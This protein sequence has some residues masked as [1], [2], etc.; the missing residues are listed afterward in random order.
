MLFNIT[1]RCFDRYKLRIDRACKPG[2]SLASV[3][4]D[5]LTETGN[6]WKLVELTQLNEHEEHMF[7]VK[8]ILQQAVLCL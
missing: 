6:L 1:P 2:I 3:C 8:A 5:H 4:N 7:G